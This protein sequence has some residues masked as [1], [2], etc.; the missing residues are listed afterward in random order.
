MQVVIVRSRCHLVSSLRLRQRLEHG[1][2]TINFTVRHH[3][4]VANHERDHKRSIRARLFTQRDRGLQEK[5][6]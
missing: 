2:G 4:N 5:E 1:P 3:S 6:F